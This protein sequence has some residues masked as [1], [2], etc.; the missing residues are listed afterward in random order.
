M[1]GRQR[2]VRKHRGLIVRP[3]H[4]FPG[5]DRTREAEAGM[6]APWGLLG[7]AW[8][9]HFLLCRVSTK[10][11]RRVGGELLLSRVNS[12]NDCLRHLRQVVELRATR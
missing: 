2:Q 8:D 5:R 10:P 9:S 6:T 12:V 7:A 11:P 3:V 1:F 4:A